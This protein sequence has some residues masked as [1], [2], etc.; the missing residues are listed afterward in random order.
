MGMVPAGEG[1]AEVVEPVFERNTGDGDAELRGIGE[2]RQTLLPGW[3]LLTEDDL[4]LGSVQRL[5]QADPALQ[6][7]APAVRKPGVTAPHL[8]ENCNRS[9]SRC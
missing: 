5:P 7:P 1:E 3:M 2:I 9:Q 4:P 6:S 8:I